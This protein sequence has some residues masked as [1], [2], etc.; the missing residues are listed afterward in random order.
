MLRYE[1]VIGIISSYDIRRFE[2]EGY[3]LL[4][5]NVRLVGALRPDYADDFWAYLPAQGPQDPALKQEAERMAAE[6]LVRR[7]FELHKD[8]VV[9]ILYDPPGQLFG[10]RVLFASTGWNVDIRMTI[11]AGLNP[12]S[13]RTAQTMR[14]SILAFAPGLVYDERTGERIG[15]DALSATS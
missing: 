4:F 15:T 1:Q 5:T 13:F 12:G 10:G 14:D 7:S 8:K 2:S 3:S 11:L 6:I 9:K